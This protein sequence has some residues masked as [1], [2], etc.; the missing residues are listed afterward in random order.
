[1]VSKAIDVEIEA[2]KSAGE[3]EKR[4]SN[5]QNRSDSIVYTTNA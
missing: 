3:N 5:V 1:M 4:K 2:R